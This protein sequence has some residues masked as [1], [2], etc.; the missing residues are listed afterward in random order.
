MGCVGSYLAAGQS[1]RGGDYL[2][3]PNSQYSAVM[4]DDGNFVLYWGRWPDRVLGPMWASDTVGKTGVTATMQTDG[5]FVLNGG[6]WSTGTG[7]KSGPL[8]A[9]MQDNG[10]FA[11]WLGTPA[12]STSWY[13]NTGTWQGTLA[14]EVDAPYVGEVTVSPGGHN[15]GHI[16]QGKTHRGMVHFP[17]ARNPTATFSVYLGSQ[18]FK[19]VD[20]GAHR[21]LLYTMG[22]LSLNPTA[23]PTADHGPF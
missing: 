15:S 1:L 18:S 7:G 16:E 11:L 23:Y 6:G 22:G 5:N 2:L 13:Y 8:F 17:A 10:D 20:L 4:Q 9:A 12:A 21:S 19:V 3:S 14:V